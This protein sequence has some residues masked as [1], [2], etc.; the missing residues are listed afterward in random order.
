MTYLNTCVADVAWYPASLNFL[1]DGSEQEI[2]IGEDEDEMYSAV[3][4]RRFQSVL[5]KDG[6][7]ALGI[8]LKSGRFHSRSDAIHDLASKAEVQLDAEV[9]AWRKVEDVL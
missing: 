9:K 2:L 7:R 5:E 6:S 4:V 8:V 1:A 3:L